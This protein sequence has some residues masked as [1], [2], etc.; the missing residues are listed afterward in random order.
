MLLVRLRHPRQF[1]LL[2]TLT[3]VLLT[4]PAALAHV[5]AGATQGFWHGLEHPLG[6]LDHLLAMVAVGLWAIQLGGVAVGVVP[7]AFIG[8]MT[9]GAVLG[10]AGWSLPLVEPLIIASDFIFGVLVLLGTRLPLYWSAPLVGFLALF[11]GYAHG[12]EM[13]GDV[14]GWSYGLGFALATLGLNGLGLLAGQLIRRFCP[15][16]T[17]RW[18]GGAILIGS[19]YVLTQALLGG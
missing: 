19:L 1:V 9:L 15:P 4:M 18:A 16:V 11:H 6:G 12:T 13:P 5:Q 10:M 17:M 2:L 7:L 14:S 8:V 3:G